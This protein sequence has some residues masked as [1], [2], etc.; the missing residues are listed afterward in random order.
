MRHS[1]QFKHLVALACL[2][3]SY[4]GSF[5]DIADLA[6]IANADETTPFEA[7]STEP[8]STQANRVSENAPNDNSLG[9]FGTQA[10]S[11]TELDA[12]EEQAFLEAGNF[13][14]RYV[15]QIEVFGAQD[16]N[17][18]QTG[19]QGPFSGTVLDADGWIVTS[20]HFFRS[21]P[22]SITVVLPN[23]ER[24]A[25]K[26]VARDYSR[27]LALLK[28]EADASLQIA[29]PSESAS[30]MVGQWTIALGKSF[31][32][33]TAS[34]SVGI[35]S[36]Q[37][38]I[39]NKAIQTDCKISPQN[40]G[41][42]LIDLY[43]NCM[44]ILTT[45]NPGISTEGEV[46]QWYDSGIGFAIPFADILER[47]PILKA[48]NDIHSGQAGFGIRNDDEFFPGLI[49]SGV[50][51]GSPAFKSGLKAG[52]E[53]LRAGRSQDALVDVSTYTN[54]KH[55]MGPI[56]AGQSLVLEVQRT[57]EKATVEL[58]L[59][60][61]LPKYQEP[62]LGVILAKID[63]GPEQI[64]QIADG[65]PAAKAGLKVGSRITRLNRES[66]NSEVTFGSLLPFL[67]FREPVLLTLQ[68][69]TKQE[70]EVSVQ[71]TA[72]PN[73]DVSIGPVTM[74]EINQ[75]A[76][77]QDE[78]QSESDPETEPAKGI[79]QIPLGDIKNKAFAI[80][81]NQYSNNM[82]H[83][84]LVVYAEAGVNDAKIW[85]DL[86]EKFC[87]DNRWICVVIQ[88]AEEAQWSFEEVEVG[89]RIR[90]Y[91]DSNYTLDPRRSCVAGFGSGGVMAL[92]SSSSFKS[93]WLSDAKVPARLRLTQATPE[94]RRRC[95]LNGSDPGLLKLS[96]LLDESGYSC[97]YTPE[98]L[99]SL[100]KSDALSVQDKP[101]LDKAKRWLRHLE[102]Q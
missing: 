61:E 45:L 52:D 57:G 54:L 37:G 87:S 16:A 2:T 55:V 30:W 88:S 75:G 11:A 73:S 83:G 65:S 9:S 59:V 19:G 31:D 39:W 58:N 17:S 86:W 70:I 4:T 96:K 38:R 102:V 33:A 68:D 28:T 23:G 49:V 95:F 21:Q 97:V 50:S 25:A 93:L 67:D 92:V 32:P 18:L 8:T 27:E 74:P 42:P 41:G 13:A 90:S 62:Y 40:Y 48:G 64:I 76:V 35:L 69:E 6:R 43:G 98:E 46:E 12:L 82:P 94:D 66:I 24:Q 100:L 7:T 63:E 1:L 77:A 26:L 53:I 80:V 36:A 22:A 84:L 29:A 72:R 47:L 91:M 85:G 51:P 15:V 99:G 71:L 56:D 5:T 81:P 34:R 89:V 3:F 44:G 10:F 60:K 79:V 14:Q 101:I 78:N 20:N